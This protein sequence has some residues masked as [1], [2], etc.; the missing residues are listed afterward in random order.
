[1]EKMRMMRD[2][3]GLQQG[4]GC[5][6]Q[7]MAD[8]NMFG[9]HHIRIRN[10]QKT[11]HDFKQVLLVWCFQFIIVFYVIIDASLDI[12]EIYKDQLEP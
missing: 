2:K 6:S 8:L 1:M 7:F 4:F 12:S 11:Q 9:M 5:T 3:L 10:D